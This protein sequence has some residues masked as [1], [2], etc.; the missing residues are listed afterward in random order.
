MC[1]VFLAV[2]ANFA[3]VLATKVCNWRN[4]KVR[5]NNFRTLDF[6]GTLNHEAF[7]ANTEDTDILSDHRSYLQGN[8]KVASRLTTQEFGYRVDD[9]GCDYIARCIF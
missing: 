8:N 3:A 7:A 9:A 1:N 5:P 6:V 4:I 2:A